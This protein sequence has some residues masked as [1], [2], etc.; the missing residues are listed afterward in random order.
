MT[1]LLTVS[2][3]ENPTLHLLQLSAVPVLRKVQDLARR[4]CQIRNGGPGERQAR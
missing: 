4:L 2:L 3:R 1:T